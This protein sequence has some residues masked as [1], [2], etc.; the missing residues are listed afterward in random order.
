MKYKA[1]KMP[2]I[3]EKPRWVIVD[4]DD[5]IINKNPSREELRSL[6]R[7]P[8]KKQKYTR[9]QL[10]SF[11]VQSYEKNGRIPI[12]LDFNNSPKYPNFSTYIRH[13]GSWNNAIRE[14]GLWN[15][16]YNP[17]NACD[18]CGVNFEDIKGWGHPRQEYDENG[19]PTGKWHCQHCWEVYDPNSTANIIKSMR[20]SRMDS[21][22]PN[23]SKGKGDRGQELLCKWK[24][25]KDLNKEN[26]NYM[27]PIDCFDESTGLYYQVMT[28]YY[29]H[30]YR[31][32]YQSFRRIQNSFRK[33]YRFKSLFLFCISKDGNTVE[34]ILEIPEKEIICRACINIRDFSREGWYE[35]YILKD[36]E[37][38]KNVNKIW[39]ERQRQE[40]RN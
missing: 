21:L 27:S 23:S 40:I 6:D 31:R 34:I 22:D 17:T 5:N 11:L 35:K 24:R 10:L 20:D 37:E 4:E 8:F 12:E 36:E 16:R 28:A 39:D 9:I 15:K 7:R 19:K 33:G 30:I 32:W 3:G 18:R 14:A 38:K 1:W 2:G 29:S 13:F 26:D 25:F